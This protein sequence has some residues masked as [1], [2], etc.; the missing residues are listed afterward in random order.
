M[1]VNSLSRALADMK[2]ESA[3]IMGEKARSQSYSLTRFLNANLEYLT[4]GAH[5]FT[6]FSLLKRSMLV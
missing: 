4:M 6:G 1:V 5:I 2:N 3:R